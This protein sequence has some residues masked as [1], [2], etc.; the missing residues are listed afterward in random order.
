[1]FAYDLRLA[2]LSMK[3]HPG[4]AAL[5]VLA[6]AL[7]IAVCTVT[8]TI[9]HAMSTNPIQWKSD[10]LYAVTVDS[11]DPKEPADDDQPEM[12]PSQL[13]YRDA[14]ALQQSDVPV[15]SAIMFKSNAV[16][17]SARK[18]TKPFRAILRLTTA[19]FFGLFDVP[20]LYGSAWTDAADQGA[21]P[22]VVLSRK[23][24]DKA[25][26]GENSVGRTIRLGDQEFRVVGVLDSWSPSPKFYD[27]NNGSFADIEDAFIPFRRGEVDEMQV[28]GNTN[29]WKSEVIESA[30]DF[31]NSECV[32]IQMWVELANA[33]DRD[34]YQAFVDNYVRAQKASGRLQRPLNDRLFD[35][36]Q[37][38]DFNR[39][40]K[41][42]NRVLIGIALLFL[43]VCLVNV[44]GLLLAKFLNGAALTGLRRALGASRGDILRQHLAEVLIVGLAGGALGLLLAWGGLA[45]IRAIYA[46]NFDT[47]ENLTR[48]DLT[49]VLVTLGLS[50]AAGLGAGIYPAWR[51]GRTAPAVYLKAQ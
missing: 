6:V 14:I 50:L 13:T 18:G 51:I 42:D 23:S 49:V 34:R 39:V 26:G 41:R 40:V 47:Y 37:W 45:G 17:D 38:L 2:L 43:A 21:D 29:C 15:R 11:W 25:F 3:R 33:K 22:V 32:W 30:Q 35:V 7:G 5:M 31:R 28:A 10:N 44:V 24:N 46:G 12:P 20:F 16:V 9:Y 19:D 8:F 4:L 48:M 27:L 36:D 1:M